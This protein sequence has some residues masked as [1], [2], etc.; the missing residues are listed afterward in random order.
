[1]NR[2]VLLWRQS[3]IGRWH[4]SLSASERRLVDWAC[5][6]FVF[7]VLYVG[8][9]QPASEFRDSQVTR[10]Q[11]ESAGLDWMRA[12]ESVARDRT[13]SPAGGGDVNIAK[14]SGSARQFGMPLQRIQ[15]L[16]AGGISIQLQAQPFNDVVRLLAALRRDHGF[17]VVNASVDSHS[18]GLVNARLSIK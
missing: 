10:F 12:N 14:V 8:V 3:T 7:V 15:S 5:A 16:P 4:E 6:L 9:W 2:I 1:M 17:R 13:K 11:N 18:E